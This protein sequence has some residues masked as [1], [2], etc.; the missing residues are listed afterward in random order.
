MA[1]PFKPMTTAGLKK[2]FKNNRRPDVSFDLND[3]DII[4]IE[5]SFLDQIRKSS[6]R[7]PSRI[8]RGSSEPVILSNK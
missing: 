2:I 3:A 6:V 7:I 1:F 5:T 4:E 8:H